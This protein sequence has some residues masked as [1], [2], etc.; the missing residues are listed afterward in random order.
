M[1]LVFKASIIFQ[2]TKQQDAAFW[3]LLA[4]LVPSNA[5]AFHELNGFL[6]QHFRL[7]Q[8]VVLEANL[9]IIHS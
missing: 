4:I 6:P 8:E 9:P 2:T 1:F 3:I 7:N 5:A